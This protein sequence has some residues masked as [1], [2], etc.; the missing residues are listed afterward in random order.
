MNI[1]VVKVTM[2]EKQTLSNLVKM[3][4][5]EWSQYNKFDVNDQGEYK[6]EHHLFKFWEKES[7]YPFFIKVNGKLAGFVLVNNEFEL[8]LDSDYAI[9]EFFVMYKY[10]RGGVGRYAAKAVFDMFHGKWE[11]VRH[12]HNAD[13]VEFWDSVVKE[14][15]DNKYEITKSCKDIVYNDGTLGDVI[16]FIN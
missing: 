2:E 4:C 14:Y 9:S 11:I 6:F 16:S 3:Y 7:H 10:R 13:S 12:P 8:H 5:Y 1:E 15:T